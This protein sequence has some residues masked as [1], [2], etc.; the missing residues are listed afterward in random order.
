[1]R[2]KIFCERY[3]T[4]NGS[5]KTKDFAFDTEVCELERLSGIR[6]ISTPS[7]KEGES[8]EE[9][10]SAI[11]DE[12]ERFFSELDVYIAKVYGINDNEQIRSKSFTVY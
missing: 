2:I 8:L 3:T 5:V 7:R 1:M 10:M 4:E 11:E 12:K 6:L 9:Y